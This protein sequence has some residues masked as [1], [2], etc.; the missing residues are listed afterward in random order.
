MKSRNFVESLSRGLSILSLLAGSSSPLTLTELSQRLGLSK[1]SI[2]RLTFTLQQLGYI[3]RDASNK[4][5]RLG[6]KTL[7]IG[8]SATRNL[9]LERL[10]Y[11]YLEEASREMG[12]AVNLAILDGK[13]IVYVGRHASRQTLNVNMQIGSRRPLHCTSMGKAILA[14]MPKHQLERILRTLELT[15]FTPRTIT[16]IQDLRICLERVRARGFATSN[17]EMEIGVRSVSAPLR[18]STGGVFSAVNIAAP[19]IRVSLR[20]LETVLAEKV[21]QIA[22]KISFVLGYNGEIGPKPHRQ[23]QM[24]SEEVR[25]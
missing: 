15:S 17:E 14:F 11:P 6:P 12:E 1:G 21:M 10:A 25:G 19:T 16:T 3:E 22:D 23:G 20:K 7:S 24:I 13:E 8:F 2:Q 18:N 5:F 9:D 4:T